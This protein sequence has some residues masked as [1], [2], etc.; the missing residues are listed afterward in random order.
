MR[1][2]V[3]IRGKTPM[4]KAEV[5][6]VSI[7]KLSIDGNSRRFLDVGAGTG[8][9]ALQVARMFPHVSVTAIERSGEA[10]ALIEQNRQ[11]LLLENVDIISAEAPIPLENTVFDAIFIGGSGGKLAEIIDWSHTLLKP[12]G[13]LVLNFILAENVLEAAACLEKGPW[14]EVEVIQLQVSKWHELGKG[15]YFKPQNP[16]FIIACQ[17]ER[18]GTA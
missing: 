8:S 15:H 10:L 2:E 17:K 9:V 1:D 5:R 3:F 7:D 16:T 18:S 12:G 14:H 13:Q 4:T 11:Q 6:A